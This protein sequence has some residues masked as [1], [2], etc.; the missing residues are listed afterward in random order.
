M[1]KI[2]RADRL[3]SVVSRFNSLLANSNTDFSQEL[4][5]E[6]NSLIADSEMAVVITADTVIEA[7]SEEELSVSA[8]KNIEE[9]FHNWRADNDI[10]YSEKALSDYY[11]SDSYARVVERYKESVLAYCF[12]KGAYGYNKLED[13]VY[14]SVNDL[15]ARAIKQ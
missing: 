14:D 15:V 9:D 6:L 13:T 10:D 8:N 11:E 3:E 5:A 7:I 4:L 2:I 1:R 12:V